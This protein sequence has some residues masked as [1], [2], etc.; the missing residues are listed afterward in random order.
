LIVTD[1]LGD[2]IGL[3]FNTIPG[4]D[5][6]TTHDMSP[7]DGDKDDVVTMP[8][9]LVGDYQIR[10]VAEPGGGGGVY[11]LG[12]RIDGSVMSMLAD[13]EPTPPPGEVATLTYNAPWFMRGD[14]NGDWWINVTDVVYLINYLFLIPP[15]PAPIP[16][17]A[18]D[19]SCD[20]VTNVTDVVY[21]INYL[22]LVPPGPPPCS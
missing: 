9:R 18:G 1:P 14:V 22:F 8:D 21:L 19:A 5:Y 7:P 15:G 6:D 17:E 4:A 11:S 10:V 12:I 2:S 20:G 3:G 16:L 13:S